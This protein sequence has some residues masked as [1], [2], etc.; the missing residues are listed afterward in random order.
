MFLSDFYF[1]Q[2]LGFVVGHQRL[3][4]RGLLRQSPSASLR[5]P[6]VTYN[7]TLSALGG[8]AAPGAL[9]RRA[10]QVLRELEGHAVRAQVISFNSVAR[11]FGDRVVG[12][13]MGWGGRG[14]MEGG[15][16]EAQKG[17]DLL[18]PQW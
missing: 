2:G 18:I 1:L 12:W 8:A 9:W 15:G 16:S 4:D 17:C 7:A 13:G 10:V 11:W 14:P 6:V 3:I 5:C